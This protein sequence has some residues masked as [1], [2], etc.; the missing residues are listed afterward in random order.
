MVP[1]SF[2][3]LDIKQTPL[4]LSEIF[5][6]VSI[7]GILCS[8]CGIYRLEMWERTN[9]SKHIINKVSITILNKVFIN[10]VLMNPWKLFTDITFF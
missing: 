5:L 2:K 1:L 6:Q 9:T 3:E 10:K 4:Y 7:D 8:S